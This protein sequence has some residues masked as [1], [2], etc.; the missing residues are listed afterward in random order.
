VSARIDPFKYEDA[1]DV[2]YFCFQM[3]EIELQDMGGGGELRT[4]PVLYNIRVYYV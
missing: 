1:E 2:H 4:L 3:K